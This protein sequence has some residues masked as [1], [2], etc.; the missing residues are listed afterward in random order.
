VKNRPE[1][2]ALQAFVHA[3]EGQFDETEG[4]GADGR[5]RPQGR[6]N[7]PAATILNGAVGR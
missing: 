5:T 2:P 1:P 7:C 3:K 6:M 4:L